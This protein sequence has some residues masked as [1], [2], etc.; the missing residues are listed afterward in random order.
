MPEN[1]VRRYSELKKIKFN[2]QNS[3][4]K[5]KFLKNNVKRLQKELLDYLKEHY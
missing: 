1:A 4:L 2:L 5:I 3:E